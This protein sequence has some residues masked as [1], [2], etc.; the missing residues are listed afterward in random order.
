MD[1][2]SQL[3]SH[4]EKAVKK[5][6]HTM[7][8][9]FDLEKAYDTVW[10]S[11][12]LHSLHEM[13]LRGNLPHFI[14]NFLT[15]RKFWVRISS[16]YS[17]LADQKE[18]V[19]QGSVLSV[20]CFAIAINDIAKTLSKEVNCTLYVDDFT[21]FV[22]AK[23]ECTSERL[24]QNTISKLEKWAKEKG[25]KFSENKTVF[26]KFSKKKGLDPILKIYGE[27]N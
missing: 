19:P 10:R 16:S 9:F 21:I 17:D 4:V 23:K 14:Q 8:V 2:F 24:L 12:I 25:M 6:K 27:P 15:D 22:S 20:T 26:K 3:T 11:E 13:G 1:A 7:A 5:G 18:G